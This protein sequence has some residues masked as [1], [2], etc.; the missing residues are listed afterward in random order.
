MHRCSVKL[1]LDCA[2]LL[3]LL[4]PLQ[5][6][7]FQ[8]GATSYPGMTQPFSMGHTSNMSSVGVRQDSMGKWNSTAAVNLNYFLLWNSYTQEAHTLKAD[9]Q[10]SPLT[11]CTQQHCAIWSSV[12][13]LKISLSDNRLLTWRRTRKWQNFQD[14][15]W[16]AL[17]FKCLQF[18]Y[19]VFPL[20]RWCA[21]WKVISCSWINKDAAASGKNEHFL[22]FWM[23]FIDGI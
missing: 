15:Y 8:M 7:L 17:R 16:V 1:N 20:R 21:S 2:F 10:T 19:V 23:W 14:I 4:L 3:L 22:E 9:R 5:K 6:D 11:N 12:L 18:S 13:L